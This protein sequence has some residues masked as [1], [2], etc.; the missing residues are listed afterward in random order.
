MS[1]EK[2]NE[3]REKLEGDNLISQEQLDQVQEPAE[4]A[5]VLPTQA[6]DLGDNP[7]LEEEVKQDN[8]LKRW[9][10]QYVGD[11]Y[12]PEDNVITVAMA[13]QAFME[14]F[15][16][17]L[18][19]VAEENWIRGYKQGVFD[20]EAGVK[21]ALEQAGVDVENSQIKLSRNTPQQELY[22]RAVAANTPQ[23]IDVPPEVV[24]QMQAD[25]D[26]DADADGDE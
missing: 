18:M 11:K 6:A 20:S 2:Q 1:E 8:E 25:A 19:V 12:K 4:G 5:P 21:A 23:E 24:E 22:E 9:F 13:V 7:D 14:E 16:E 3:A 17:F 10:I 15:P 26:A